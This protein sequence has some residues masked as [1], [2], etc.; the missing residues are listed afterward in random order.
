MEQKNGGMLNILMSNLWEKGKLLNK[1]S[2][3]TK[4]TKIERNNALIV[5]LKCGVSVY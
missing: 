1:P 3:N 5:A 4:C 2:R